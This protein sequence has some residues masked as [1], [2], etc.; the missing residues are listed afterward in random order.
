MDPRVLEAMTPF[1]LEHF[2]NAA[3][4]NHPFGW[5]AEEAVDYGREQV[6]KLIGPTAC[7]EIYGVSNAQAAALR[8]HGQLTLRR[9]APDAGCNFLIVDAD[10]Q[11]TLG[12]AVNLPDWAFWATLRRPSDKNENV[13]LFK[14]VANGANNIRT[15]RTP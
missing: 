14:R 6:A 5:E 7:V 8:Y 3:S 15:T 2:G 11:S 9:A 1:F 10:F 4:R 13:V 12:N